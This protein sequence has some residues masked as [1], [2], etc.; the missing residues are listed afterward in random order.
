[1][2]DANK[3]LTGLVIFLALIT[4]PIWYSLMRAEAR[5]VP[6]PLIITEEKQ[7]VESTEYM[8]EKHMELLEE[9]RESVVREGVRSYKSSSGKEYEMSL[10]DTCLRCHSNKAEFCDQCHNYVGVKPNCWDCHNVPEGNER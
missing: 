8:R 2:Y 9:W 7:C 6:E 10:T 3:I 5:E 1:M 4:F